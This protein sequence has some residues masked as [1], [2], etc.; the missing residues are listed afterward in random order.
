MKI[1]GFLL[2]LLKILGIVLLWVIVA[3]IIVL[4]IVLLVKIKYGIVAEKSNKLYVDLEVTWFFK[5]VYFRYRISDKSKKVILKIFGRPFYKD[6]ED[7]TSKEEKPKEE[8]SSL[9]NEEE[10]INIKDK[11][12]EKEVIYKPEEITYKHKPETKEE[13]INE[14]AKEI[15]RDEVEKIKEEVEEDIKKY[16]VIDKIKDVWNYPDREDI[17]NLSI[18]LI[19]KLF[20]TLFP[21]ILKVDIEF[22]SDNPAQTGYVIAISSIL[23][24]YFGNDIKVKGNFKRKV[25]KGKLEAKGSFSIFKILSTLL[26]FALRKSIRKLIWKYIKHRKEEK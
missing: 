10:E 12:K 8:K 21:K 15:V 16:S 20:K 18:G 17:Q 4:A 11:P 19:K 7:F 9:D 2:T 22:G 3:L 24:L 6:K 1:L 25:L 26:R 23:V 14:E 5:I 13:K